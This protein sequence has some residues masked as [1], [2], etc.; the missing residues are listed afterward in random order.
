M[1]PFSQC[2]RVDT[3]VAWVIGQNAAK[4]HKDTRTIFV[5]I[6]W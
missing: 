1:E 5:R 3:P 2:Q 4:R 6:E